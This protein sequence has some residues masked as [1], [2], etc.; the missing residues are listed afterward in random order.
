MPA[1]HEYTRLMFR[2]AGCDCSGNNMLIHKTRNCLWKF[3]DSGKKIIPVFASD[4]LTAE[5]LQEDINSLTQV[6]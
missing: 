3:D 2:N 5:D 4:I 1:E 6:L